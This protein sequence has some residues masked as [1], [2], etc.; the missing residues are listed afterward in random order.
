[1]PNNNFGPTPRFVKNNLRH[2]IKSMLTDYVYAPFDLPDVVSPY[3]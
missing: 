1:M 3:G 2:M